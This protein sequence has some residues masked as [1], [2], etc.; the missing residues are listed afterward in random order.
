MKKSDQLKQERAQKIDALSALGDVATKE[1]R[2]L[3]ATDLA[4][5]TRLKNEIQG[6]DLDILRAETEEIR[7]LDRARENAGGARTS[8]IA[9]DRK[10]FLDAAREIRQAGGS[11]RVQYDPEIFFRA[12]TPA[13]NSAGKSAYTGTDRVQLQATENLA[14]LDNLMIDPVTRNGQTVPFIKRTNRLTPQN[15]AYAD[16][17]TGQAYVVDAYTV[18][19]SNYYTY[20]EIHND[21]L[22]DAADRNLEEVLFEATRQDIMRQIAYDVLFGTGGSNNLTG[23]AST[24]DI[25]TI[26]LDGEYISSFSPIVDAAAK[27]MTESDVDPANLVAI[28]HPNLWAQ[29]AS[30]QAGTDGQPLQ[31]PTQ[32]AGMP[33]YP[34]RRIPIDQGT[35]QDETTIV[36]ADLS[37]W[38]LYSDGFYELSSQTG[39]NMKRDYTDAVATFRVDLATIDP[40]SACL[41]QAVKSSSTGV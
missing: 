31:R 38:V 18:A 36:V 5:V 8:S 41:I 40:G 27:L 19:L 3:S 24:A 1:N 23:I 20:L 29:F 33:F 4:E 6:M 13:S 37:K 9:R 15:K 14:W 26:D 7:E 21:V 12:M 30:L 2:G 32:I 17:L 16:E 34:Y 25:L 11:K 28:M 35:G 22:R 10:A 39:P